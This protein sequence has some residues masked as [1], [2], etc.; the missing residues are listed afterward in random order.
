MKG[1][2]SIPK[3]AFVLLLGMISLGCG[4]AER[5][6]VSG[7]ASYQGKKIE[8]GAIVF[9]S[10]GGDLPPGAAD[11]IDGKYTGNVQN[12]GSYIVEVR[13]FRF[14]G[15]STD[16]SDPEVQYTQFIPPKFNQNSTLKVELTSAANEHDFALE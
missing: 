13:G 1:N 9:R 14:K 15:D 7:T 8:R 6:A 16:L 10:V 2:L 3:L 4:K 12:P 11:I 5:L